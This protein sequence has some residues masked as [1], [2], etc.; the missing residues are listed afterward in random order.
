MFYLCSLHFF[1][2]VL[3]TGWF[4]WW[5][6]SVVWQWDAADLLLCLLPSHHLGKAT[7]G[8]AGVWCLAVFCSVIH[9]IS[10]VLLVSC[11]PG[12][13]LNLCTFTLPLLE[14]QSQLTGNSDC[15]VTDLCVCV[16]LCM[17]VWNASLCWR[18][19]SQRWV[20][21]GHGLGW[22]GGVGGGVWTPYK[23]MLVLGQLYITL[24]PLTCFQF[25]TFT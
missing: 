9:C 24:G 13:V 19:H 21:N 3:P 16:S 25:P 8:K 6:C 23:I 7:L 11:A 20:P 15:L 14:P 18:G 2:S 22:G 1:V 4:P 5:I 17:C 12:C 10:G